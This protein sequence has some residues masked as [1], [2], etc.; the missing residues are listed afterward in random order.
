MVSDI[1]RII[2]AAL[3]GGSGKTI[4]SLGLTAAWRKKGYRVAPFKKGPDFIDSGWLEFAA[5]R[6]CHNLDPFL[7]TDAQIIQ[8]FFFHSA[9]SDI[10]LIEGN[11]GLYDGFDEEGRYSTAELGKLLTT[12]V[13]VIA[14]VTMA[15]RTIAALI[16][17]CQ[18]FDPDLKIVGVILNRV[19]GSRQETLVRNS[20]ERY[21]EIPVIGAV[22]KLEG[23]PFPERHMGL[24]P[25]QEREYAKKAIAWA[26]SAVEQNLDL[27]AIWRFSQQVEPLE[28]VAYYQ[29][30]QPSDDLNPD[31]PRIGFIR[32]RSFW[33][34]Y[35]EN[36]EQLKTLGAVLVEVNSITEKELPE[37]DALYIGGGFPETQAK[38]LADNKTFRDSLRK[39]IERGL[40]VYAECGGL[41]YL[42]ESLL[43]KEKTYPMV[44][45]LPLNCVM[46][47]KP[48]GHG[49]TIL[50]VTKQNPYYPVGETLK[51][52]EFHYSRPLINEAEG[53]SSVFKVHRGR[54]LDGERDGLCKKNLLATYTH[55][56]AAGHSLWGKSL[57]KAALD[58]KRHSR[59]DFLNDAKKRD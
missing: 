16:M 53:I 31:P 24:I 34:Y 38:A 5:G 45:A 8:S 10:S 23:A 49:Y 56:H 37:L 55:L 35:P 20:I 25:H 11:R 2:I 22:P 51:G 18:K 19:A 29:E 33:F 21:C 14:E 41:M 32:D 52:H 44:G 30:I 47:E 57:F 42:G 48:Q 4:L 58:N 39:R 59:K 12:P 15:T 54:G 27:Q 6:S 28:R 9:E 43:L 3:K 7:M 36:L 17:G 26:R 1:P 13:I 50:E 46:E 40:P